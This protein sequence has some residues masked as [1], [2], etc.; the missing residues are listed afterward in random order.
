MDQM[1]HKSGTYQ[2]SG[3]G[4]SLQS[5]QDGRH[6]VPIKLLEAWGVYNSKQDGRHRIICS[7]MCMCD[8]MEVQRGEGTGK[9]D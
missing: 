9:T 7:L 5:R 4:G 1:Q 3:M 6:V 8:R 2:T